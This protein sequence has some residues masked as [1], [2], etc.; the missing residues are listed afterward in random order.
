MIAAIVVVLHHVFTK[1]SFHER[2]GVT[3]APNTCRHGDMVYLLSNGP[4]TPATTTTTANTTTAG[5]IGD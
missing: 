2:N 1:A 3:H 5:M 4:T